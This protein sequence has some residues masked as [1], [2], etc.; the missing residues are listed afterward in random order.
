MKRNFLVWMVV[1]SSGVAQAD[2]LQVFS[3][4]TAFEALAVKQ[5]E[6]AGR[7]PASL[8]AQARVIGLRRDLGLS[9]EAANRSAQ[10][11]ILNAGR[12]SGLSEGQILTVFRRLP[13]VDPY[14]D[15]QSRELEIKFARIKIIHLQ[16]N[17][18]IARVESLDPIQTGLAI[19]TR[20]VLVGDYVT[21]SR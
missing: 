15:N 4:R 20:S 11:L 10:D 2:E 5:V 16:D 8:L 12:E 14:L 3:S 18:A 9:D 19:G 7:S 21:A 13:V 1:A 6:N 17:L